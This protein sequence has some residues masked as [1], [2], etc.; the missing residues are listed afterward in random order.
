MSCLVVFSMKKVF[1]TSGPGIQT[2]DASVHKP[3]LNP[4]W[5]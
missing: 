5:P 4:E 1:V 3:V 2:K